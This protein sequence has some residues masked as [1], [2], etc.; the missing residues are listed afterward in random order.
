MKEH[1]MLRIFDERRVDPLE[2]TTTE[3]TT[4][5]APEP[6]GEAQE[7]TEAIKGLVGNAVRADVG[8]LRYDLIPPLPMEQ[9]AQ[10]LTFGSQKYTDNNWL[11]GM[12]YS[13]IYAALMRHLQAWWSGEDIDPE[14]GLPHLA[15]AA[16]NVMF[17]QQLSASFP[18]GDDRVYKPTE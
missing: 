9:M 14:S 17:L 15:H 18:E 7:P 5:E 4:E 16:C 6:S 10:A 3:V 8:K 13:R 1:E 11:N 12:G 2:D